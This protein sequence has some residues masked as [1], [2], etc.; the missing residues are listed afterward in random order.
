MTTWIWVG[1]GLMALGGLFSLL[2]R[3]FRVAVSARKTRE[4]EPAVPA[5]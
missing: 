2:D 5:E 3:R 1:S 4:R